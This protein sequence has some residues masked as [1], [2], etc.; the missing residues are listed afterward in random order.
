M[1]SSSSAPPPECS[2]ASAAPSGPPAELAPAA[3]RQ[4]RFTSLG[5][6]ARRL[7]GSRTTPGSARAAIPIL[8]ST[9]LNRTAAFYTAVG[10][11]QTER[12][13]GYLLLHNGGSSC[14]SP[15]RATPHPASASCTSPTR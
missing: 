11:S 13:D 4:L 7:T 5:A 3:L 15:T 14:T 6:L 9:D 2:S 1:R 8:P 12:H 10:F